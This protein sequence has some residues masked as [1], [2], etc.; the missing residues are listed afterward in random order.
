MGASRRVVRWLKFG[1][2]LRFSRD[3]VQ[4]KGLPVLTQSSPS[5]LITHYPDR[6]KQD[7]LDGMIAQLIQKQCIREMSVTE[8][9]FFSRVF[10]VPKKSGGGGGGGS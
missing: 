5:R 3:T 9:G 6:V 4:K 8:C 2:P 10:L 7:A 1:L